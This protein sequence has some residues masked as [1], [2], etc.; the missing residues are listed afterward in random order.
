MSKGS[1]FILHHT[2]DCYQYHPNI[3]IHTFQVIFLHENNIHTKLVSF[4]PQLVV[5]PCILLK[6]F[7]LL[8]HYYITQHV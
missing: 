1:S 4:Q 8:V 5:S 3:F 2:G 6:G 7:L